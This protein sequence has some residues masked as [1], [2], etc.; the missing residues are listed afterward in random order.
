VVIAWKIQSATADGAR[1]EFD[2]ALSELQTDRIDLVT[3]YYVESPFE[4]IDIPSPGSAYESLSEA[5]SNGRIRMI[6]LTSHQ[7]STAT[8]IAAGALAPATAEQGDGFD[9][10]RP[11]DALMLRYNTAH[12][13]ADQDVFPVTD[14]ISLPVV[15]YTYLR[16]GAQMKSTPEDPPKYGIPTASEW[17]RYELANPSAAV[18]LMAPNGRAKLEDNLSLLDD[19]RAP[20]EETFASGARVSGV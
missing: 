13:G 6:G 4:W 8:S 7:R 18:A 5:K 16:W 17:Y 11:L 20:N 9:A 19:W 3:L 12:R 10:G 15:V 1:R 2:E 14:P